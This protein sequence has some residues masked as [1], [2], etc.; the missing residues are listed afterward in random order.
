MGTVTAYNMANIQSA[1]GGSN[2]ISLSEYY[3][4]GPYV[5]T[6]RSSVVREPTSGDYYTWPNNPYT[7]WEALVLGS[8]LYSQARWFG[9]S[10]NS[11]SSTTTSISSGGYT[12]YRGSY[13]RSLSD[14]YGNTYYLYGLYRESGSTISI[15]TSVPSSGT[16]SISQLYGAANP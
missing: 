7:W 6:T 12:Y 5:P 2:P 4:G 16:I 8:P 15:N 10:F 3:R 11:T 13:R 1:L 9:T 14:S